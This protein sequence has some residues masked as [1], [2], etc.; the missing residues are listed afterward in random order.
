MGYLEGK[1]AIVTGGAGGIGS[2][3]CKIYAE[4]GA[5]VLVADTGS[6]VEGRAGLDSSRVNQ[7]VEEITNNGGTALSSV[8]DIAEM[9]YAESLV[10]K[11]L[12]EWGHLDIVVCAHGILRERMI[13]NM[14]EEEWDE[15]VRIHLK[16]CF[17]ITKF[18]SV[19]WRQ[20]RNSGRLIYFTSDAGL[21]GSPGQPNYSAAHAGKLGLM[22]SNSRAL[23]KYGVTCNAI[24]PGASTRMTDRGRTVDRNNPPPSESAAG[25]ARDPKNIVPI[26][27]WLASDAGAVSNG[28]VYG[29]RGHTI[30]L[31][32]E[33][34]RERVL[35]FEQPYIEIDDLFEIWPETL[36]T[37]SFSGE[38]R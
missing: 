24:A 18:A 27:V 38:Q 33:P 16:G 19:Y 7:I 37:E 21:R 2:Q 25:T 32:R 5:K 23:A 29:A 10:K 31:F 13:F 35:Q 28:R 30:T 3:I 4:Q 34:V 12:D 22:R 11:T 9:D 20:I 15:V 14:T 8:G 36:G 17:T 6:D 26:A 1:T